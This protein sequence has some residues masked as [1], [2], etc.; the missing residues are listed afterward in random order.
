MPPI[1]FFPSNTGTWASASNARLTLARLVHTLAGD[2][3]LA[4]EILIS[5]ADRADSNDDSISAGLS[6]LQEITHPDLAWLFN[7]S[8]LRLINL[9]TPRSP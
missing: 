8:G 1:I 7:S 3:L 5:K 4:A 6:A 2:T 9:S